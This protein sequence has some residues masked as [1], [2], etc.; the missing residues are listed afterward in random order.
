[1]V[2]RPVLTVAEIDG[3][4][5]TEGA[6]G[7][8]RAGLRAAQ[9]HVA[10]AC[11][12]ALTFRAPRQLEAAREH[13]ARIERLPFARIGQPT[14]AAL[15]QLAAEIVAVARVISPTRIEIHIRLLPEMLV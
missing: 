5:D 13:I 10:V 2:K 12:D 1:M 15:A 3:R 9:G 4:D 6:D 14:A 11:P 8:Q 7:G